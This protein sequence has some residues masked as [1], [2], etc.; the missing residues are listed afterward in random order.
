MKK[1]SED[2]QKIQD[3]FSKLQEIEKRLE[4]KVE[5]YLDRTSHYKDYNE[6]LADNSG[7]FSITEKLRVSDAIK[8][9]K[10]ISAFEKELKESPDIKAFS[11]VGWEEQLRAQ[12][13]LV[14]KGIRMELYADMDDGQIMIHNSMN[15]SHS[16]VDFNFVFDKDDAYG[17]IQLSKEGKDMFPMLESALRCQLLQNG[18]NSNLERKAEILDHMSVDTSWML[19]KI[20]SLT[21]SELIISEIAKETGPFVMKPTERS[22]DKGIKDEGLRR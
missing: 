6:Y 7:G 13:L 15:N 18:A 4:K 5:G 9:Y 22:V 19:S 11:T 3:N 2:M 1:S 14:S 21:K 12:K 20:A 10:G 17:H 16:I 8:M